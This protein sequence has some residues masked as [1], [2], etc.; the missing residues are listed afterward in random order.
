M[1]YKK[2]LDLLYERKFR[3]FNELAELNNQKDFPAEG[4]H[5]ETH[6]AIKEIVGREYN[7]T[8]ALIEQ[9]IILI[10]K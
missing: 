3:L 1:L 5:C 4:C 10:A 2:L 8:Q 7:D 6:K 9:V